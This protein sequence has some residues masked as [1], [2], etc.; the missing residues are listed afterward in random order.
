MTAS[1]QTT[2]YQ[3]P[4]PLQ[5]DSVDVSGDMQLL[6]QKVEEKLL[7]KSN[8][9][10][11]TF[12]GTPLAPTA[13]VDTST[14]QLA[15]TAF[16]INQGYIKSA[17][18]FSTYAP[19]VSPALAGNPTATTQSLGDSSAKLATTAFVSTAVN[20]IIPSVSG[21]VGKFLKTDGVTASWEQISDSDINGLSTVINNLSS[22]YSPLN[23]SINNSLSSSYTLVLS[24][25]S[26][27][28]E[29]ASG[30]ANT[31]KIPANSSV[32]FPIG[33]KIMITQLGL[34][35]TTIQA[36]NTMN[37][38]VIGTPGLKLR[39]QW[40]VATIIKRDTNMWIVFGDI[41]A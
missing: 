15:T 35:Q 22:V 25:S 13:A 23:I 40:S 36:E 11:P 20:S 39:D 14:T 26:K 9:A 18:A 1:G 2:S 6:A 10:S 12:T 32:E 4:Y 5:T 8:L 31:L 30:S 21:N 37:T 7:L 38:T 27:M 29:M 17:Y 33:T 24:D 28:I 41:V 16:V 19:L 3:L 34:G